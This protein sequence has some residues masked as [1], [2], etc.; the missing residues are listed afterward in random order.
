ML[1]NKLEFLLDVTGADVIVAVSILLGVAVGQVREDILLEVC[2]PTMA[3]D[4]GLVLIF[5]PLT[6]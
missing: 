5:I 1:P 3:D 2:A 4:H 6:F